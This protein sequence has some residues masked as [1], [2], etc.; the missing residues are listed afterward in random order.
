M[1]VRSYVWLVLVLSLFSLPLLAHPEKDALSDTI[2]TQDSQFWEA[3]NHCD[4]EKM[5]QFFWPISSSTTTRAVRLLDWKRLSKLFARTSAATPIS[6]CDA[7]RF[8]ELCR[9]FR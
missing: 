3:Y 1:R 6:A 8:Q 5:S 7:K 4:V 9:Y 2:L